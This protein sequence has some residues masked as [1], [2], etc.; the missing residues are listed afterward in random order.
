MVNLRIEAENVQDV[1]K[2]K[3]LKNK[4]KSSPVI[5]L[6]PKDTGV[7]KENFQ[8]PKL[9]HYEQKVILLDCIQNIKLLWI[10][11]QYTYIN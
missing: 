8:G 6:C 9:D 4:Q 2:S 3:L 7:N 5:D 10:G 11:N 1:T